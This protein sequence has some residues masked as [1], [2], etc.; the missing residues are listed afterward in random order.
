[1]PTTMQR[2]LSF[3]STIASSSVRGQARLPRSLVAA[4]LPRALRAS[5]APGDQEPAQEPEAPATVAVEK[6]E[7][8]SKPAFE[9]KRLSIGPV[10]VGEGVSFGSLPEGYERAVALGVPGMALRLGSGIFASGY[11]VSLEEDDGADVYAVAR[12]NGQRTVET[13]KVS[14]Y[15]RPAQPL[16]L[17]EFEGCPFCKKV[18]EA[19]NV[20]DINV[21]YYPC[22]S[23]GP[24]YREK[25]K[26]EG[27]KSQFP[28]IVDP[29]NENKA[30]Y[31]SDDI[32]EYLYETYGPGKDGIPMALRLGALTTLT[33]GLSLAP[34]L[35]AGSRYR[36][37]KKPEGM[38]PLKLWAYEA[39]PF[40]KI[41]K[42]ALCALEIPHEYIPCTRGSP[43]RQELYERLGVFQVPYLEDPNTGVNMFESGKM[44]D[45]LNETYAA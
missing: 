22:P 1:M 18:R 26:A 32:I 5:A 39:S 37:S 43:H 9:K 42:E 30:L 28:Y 33:A 25:V 13:S 6:V 29:N 17:Y 12:Y 31:E 34:R 19:V 41:V 11:S 23:N 10:S 24:T 7:A 38:Q 4:R 16:E 14:E 45:Y 40:C 27:G 20:L 15:P 35:G 8:V 36:E 44:V 21:V 3:S 2:V